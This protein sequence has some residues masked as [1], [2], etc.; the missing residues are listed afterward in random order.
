MA[1]PRPPTATNQHP[2]ARAGYLSA[3]LR[4]NDDV[5]RRRGNQETFADALAQVTATPARQPQ[6]PPGHHGDYWGDRDHRRYELV[7]EQLLPDDAVELAA[8]GAAVV[9][10]ACG[11]GGKQCELDWLSR[12][13]AAL[14]ASSGPPFLKQSKHGR[15]DLEHWRSVD[16][17]DLVVVAVDVTWGN[18]IG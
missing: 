10:D 18:R 3:S 7:T 4:Q 14:V 15:A 16:G 8:K 13:A 2:Q 6:T 9:Y 11:C 5:A 12:S 17:R 1:R